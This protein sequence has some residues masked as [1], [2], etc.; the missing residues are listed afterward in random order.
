MKK[1]TQTPLG[2]E[3]GQVDGPDLILIA[4]RFKKKQKKQRILSG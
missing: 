4:S 2:E 3:N 1:R